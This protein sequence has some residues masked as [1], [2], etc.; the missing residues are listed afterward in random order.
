MRLPPNHATAELVQA[1]AETRDLGKHLSTRIAQITMDT[2]TITPPA[3][4]PAL[5]QYALNETVALTVAGLV[6]FAELP[7]DKKIQDRIA[8]SVLRLAGMKFYGTE[9][10]HEEETEKLLAYLRRENALRSPRG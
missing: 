10:Q 5:L 9:K 4:R 6:A 8:A 1:L 7:N 2:L 3:M